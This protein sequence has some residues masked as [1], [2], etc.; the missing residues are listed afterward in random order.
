[1]RLKINGE[2]V[3]ICA[4]CVG[5]GL[6]ES[7][8]D[9]QNCGTA[10]QLTPITFKRRAYWLISDPELILVHYIDEAAV[11]AQISQLHENCSNNKSE[12]MKQE[13][14]FSSGVQID[15]PIVGDSGCT[16]GTG[17][18]SMGSKTPMH[19]STVNVGGATGG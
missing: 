18:S 4:Y 10:S 2:E 11:N 19:N 13:T 14:N 7:T 17:T 15:F 6:N 5:S 3:M 9:H 8:P 1:M 12:E 16:T